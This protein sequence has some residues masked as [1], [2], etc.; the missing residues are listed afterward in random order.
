VVPETAPA[1]I[2]SPGRPT[3]RRAA[4]PPLGWRVPGLLKGMITILEDDEH[5]K[6]FAEYVA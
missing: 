3:D 2:L 4:G 6:D 1:H 5:L